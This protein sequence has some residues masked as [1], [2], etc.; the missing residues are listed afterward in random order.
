MSEPKIAF[1]VPKL[2]LTLGSVLIV[3]G[4]LLIGGAQYFAA[5]GDGAVRFGALEHLLDTH[6][7][8]RM[9]YALT[10]PVFAAPLMVL[11]SLFG[12]GDSIAA[13]YNFWL[14]LGGLALWGVLLRRHL[15]PFAWRAFLMLLLFASLMPN[16]VRHFYGEIFTVVLVGGGLAWATLGPRRRGLGWVLVVIGVA[17]TPAAVPALGLLALQ[18]AYMR[19]RARYL[20]LPIAAFAL[21]C[22]DSWLRSGTFLG[23][24]YGNDHGAKTPMPYSGLPGFSYPLIFGLLSIFFSFGKGL[25][26]FFPGLL[27]PAWR[28]FSCELR[29]FYLMCVVFLVGLVLVYAKWWAWYG[30]WCFGP[31]FFT[32][33]AL[34]AALALAVSLAQ[35]HKSWWRASLTLAVLALSVWVGIC[36][37]AF[38]QKGLGF[39]TEQNW[40][41][42]HLVW[43]VPEYSVLWHPFV[44]ENIRLEFTEKALIV[45]GILIFLWC[46]WPTFRIWLTLTRGHLC[47]LRNRLLP[48]RQWRW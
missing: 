26:W 45:Y 10:G 40:A 9:K 14:L 47:D 28:Q 19:R 38:Q 33:A 43:H 20:L 7:I 35:A 6:E 24:G 44:A 27:L 13:R 29:S 18:Q 12:T 22:L 30:G 1:S 25:I 32:F 39:A 46:A 42:E 23:G 4:A 3:L 31:R 34:P 8:P 2:H 36:A 15:T 21:V 17:N 16:A 48:L 41:L 5:M 11:D 37:A